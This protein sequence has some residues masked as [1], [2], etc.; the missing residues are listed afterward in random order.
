M[1][2]GHVILKEFF[3]DQ[4]VDFF[5]DYNSKYTDLPFLVSLEPDA[6]DAGSAPD[7]AAHGRPRRRGRPR[8]PARQVPR[9]R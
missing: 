1:A 2:M 7:A 9:R 6:S 3:V 4:Q 8:L 5:T